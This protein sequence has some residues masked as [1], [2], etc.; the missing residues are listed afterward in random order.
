MGVK[1]L[2]NMNT[3]HICWNIEAMQW[4]DMMKCS[5][6]TLHNLVKLIDILRTL[7]HVYKD[8]KNLSPNRT[9]GDKIQ[10]GHNLNFCHFLQ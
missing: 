4:V 5:T 9:L 1:L 2:V 3:I 8:S 6:K 10:L 7:Y